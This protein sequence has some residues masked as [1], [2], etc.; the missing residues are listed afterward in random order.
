MG[1]SFFIFNMK[2]FSPAGGLRD[3]GTEQGGLA[4]RVSGTRAGLY[5]L[6]DRVA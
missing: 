5:E 3:L 1:L 4:T 2:G 6:L